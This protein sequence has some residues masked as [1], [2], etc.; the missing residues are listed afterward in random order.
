MPLTGS[1]TARVASDDVKESQTAGLEGVT[2]Y[3]NPTHGIVSVATGAAKEVRGTITTLQGVQ[4]NVKGKQL[5]AGQLRFDISGQPS[6]I[7]LLRME[8]DGRIKTYKLL[9]E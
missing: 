2:V 4:L 8:V 3:P 5:G 1:A 7:Y 9:K 6:G